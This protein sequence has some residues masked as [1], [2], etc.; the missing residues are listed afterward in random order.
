MFEGLCGTCN[1]SREV[2]RE[3]HFLINLMLSNE[4]L[5]KQLNL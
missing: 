3:I 1:I 4:T 2:S 5:D